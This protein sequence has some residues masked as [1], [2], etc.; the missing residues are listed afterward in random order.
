MAGL[1]SG[2]AVAGLRVF[3]VLVLAVGLVT[4]AAA[5][6]TQSI[7]AARGGVPNA[8][9]AEAIMAR[10][11]RTIA[12][13]VDGAFLGDWRRGEAI[14]RGALGNRYA[15]PIGPGLGEGCYACHR[16]DRAESKAGTLGPSISRYGLLRDFDADEVRAA[17]AKIFNPQATK[18]CSTM[19]RFGAE[20]ILSEQDIK[21][22][23][24]YLFDPASPVNKP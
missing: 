21:D 9:E 17:Y 24:G 5:D 3:S 22:V 23:L 12:L 7:C 6:E 11:A 19:P 1:R 15:V 16:I 13:P 20:R 14:A 2:V 8:M 4:A 18:A 10:E